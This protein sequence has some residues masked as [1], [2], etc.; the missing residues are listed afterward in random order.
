LGLFVCLFVRLL[1]FSNLQIV[2]IVVVMDDGCW[3][4][5]DGDAKELSRGELLFTVFALV[6]FLPIGYIGN[7]CV[8]CC[9][10]AMMGG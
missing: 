2:V 7:C 9:T 4:L 6:I 5:D 1:T 10:Q 8:E 3:M